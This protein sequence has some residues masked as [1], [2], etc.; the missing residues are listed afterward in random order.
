MSLLHEVVCA[1]HEPLRQICPAGQRAV[2]ELQS[3]QRPIVVLQT[4]P[5]EHV[6]PSPHSGSSETLTQTWLRHTLPS[7]HSAFVA[8]SMGPQRPLGRHV[9]APGHSDGELQRTASHVPLAPQIWPASHTLSST[10]AR[11]ALPPLLEHPETARRTANEH[12]TAC[13]NMR[14]PKPLPTL[15]EA[16]SVQDNRRQPI[17]SIHPAELQLQTALRRGVTGRWRR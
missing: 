2:V 7:V 4:L 5:P 9:D 11:P 15:D 12:T 3:S 8:H 6:P 1:S 13:G 16:K 10:H 14:M 17:G